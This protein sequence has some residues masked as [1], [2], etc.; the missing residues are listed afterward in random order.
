MFGK[1][2]QTRINKTLTKIQNAPDLTGPVRTQ[3]ATFVGNMFPRLTA[4]EVQDYDALSGEIDRKSV[5]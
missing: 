4:A 1:S 3:I 2:T 5:V